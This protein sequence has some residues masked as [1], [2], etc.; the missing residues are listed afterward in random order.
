MNGVHDVGG[1]TCFG[2]VARESGEPIFH[3]EWE[4]RVFALTMAAM[5]GKLEVIDVF[6]HA[7]ERMDPAHYLASTYYE[8]WL[9]ALVTIGSESRLA[10]L[11]PSDQPLTAPMVDPLVAK[12]LSVLRPEANIN[13]RFQ[14]GDSVVA[15][16]LNPYGHTRLPRYVR[17]RRGV[18]DRIHGNHVFPDAVAHG[19]G[20]EP[21]PLYSVRFAARELWGSDASKTQHVYVDLWDT[22]LES[23]A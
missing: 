6:R 15:R 2:A 4:R 17:G 8:H 1:L 3:E 22:Y 14:V 5:I 19:L 21:Q 9:S 18:I 7:I 13:H 12:G 16:N 10:D 20:E 11:E 23:P